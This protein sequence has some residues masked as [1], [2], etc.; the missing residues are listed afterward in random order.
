MVHMKPGAG[1]GKPHSRWGQAGRRQG[2]AP[3]PSTEEWLGRLAAL[4]LLWMMNMVY[5]V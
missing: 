1:A 2:Q 3:R 5:Q 4:M